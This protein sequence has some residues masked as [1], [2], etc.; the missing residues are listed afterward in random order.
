[1]DLIA[2]ANVYVVILAGG[3]GTRFWPKSRQKRPKQLCKIGH[4]SLTMIEITLGRLAGFVPPERRLIITHKDQA[5]G[6]RKLVGG[7]CPKIIAEPEAKNTAAALT[8]AALEIEAMAPPGSAPIMV[9]LHADHVIRDEGTFR[10][11]LLSAVTLAQ[12]GYLTL[13]GIPPR[14]PDT[15][16][17]YIE[18]GNPLAVG[19]ARGF[20]VSSFREKPPLAAAQQYV[21]SGNFFW[22]AGLFIWRVD[23]LLEELQGLLPQ[24]L[25][26]LRKVLAASGK[27]QSFT[28]LG[29]ETFAA[30]YRELEA[31][32]IDHAV[33]EK[34]ARVAVVAASMGWQD[35][36]SWDALAVCFGKGEQENLSYGESMLIECQGVTTDSDGPLIAGLGLKDLVLV[37]SG[38]VVMVCPRDRAQDVKKFVERLKAE[39]RKDLL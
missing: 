26:P 17:G 23:R 5:D 4:D 29:A 36:G 7:L 33:L 31:I 38:G 10:S 35:V 32:S 9:S 21:Q 15:G 30:I 14:T 3:S 25:N 19:T 37:A 28:R 6:T 8:L 24:T 22:N 27:D 11:S 20:T 2:P 34:S 12:E 1:M 18:K 13:I 39:G 16:F